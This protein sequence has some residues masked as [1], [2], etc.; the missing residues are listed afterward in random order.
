M[1]ILQSS[2]AKR[3]KHPGCTHVR[4]HDPTFRLH[5]PDGKLG[6]RN[7]P[8]VKKLTLK[9]ETK[10]ANG[11]SSGASSVFVGEVD[12]KHMI[13]APAKQEFSQYSFLLK[14]SLIRG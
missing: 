9:T 7:I 11:S 12:G 8:I 2:D 13:A 1:R 4:G 6:K 10:S 5:R 3:D 14:R